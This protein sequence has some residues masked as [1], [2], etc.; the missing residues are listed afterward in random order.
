MTDFCEQTEAE[1]A[2]DTTL[3]LLDEAHMHRTINQRLD[4]AAA[5]FTVSKEARTMPLTAD[6]FLD[7]V[8]EFTRHM[9]RHGFAVARDLSRGQARSEAVFILEKSYQGQGGR[10]YDAAL[11]DTVSLGEKGVEHILSYIT[12]ALKTDQRRKYIR[13]VLGAH[14][15]PLDWKAKRDLAEILLQRLKNFLPD[16]VNRCPPEQLADFYPGLIIDY[17]ETKNEFGHIIFGH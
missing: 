12:E 1:C 5:P 3:S 11:V 14:V 16:E 4:S 7:T 9:Y 13:W 17:I 15:D 2:L 10:G 6:R 8:A